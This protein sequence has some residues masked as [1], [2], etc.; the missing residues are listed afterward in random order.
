M[1]RN[2]ESLNYILEIGFSE[3]KTLAHQWL[4]KI[5][6]CIYTRLAC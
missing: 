5:D 6:I 4:R 1:G 2:G 3:V